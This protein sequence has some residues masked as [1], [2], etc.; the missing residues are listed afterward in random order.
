MKELINLNVAVRLLFSFGDGDDY[1]GATV[2]PL[3][4]FHSPEGETR[5]RIG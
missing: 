2:P 4:P 3:P 5:P 1:T